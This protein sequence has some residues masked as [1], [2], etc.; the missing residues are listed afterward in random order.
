M[1]WEETIKYI[2]K[3]PEYKF[4]VETAYLEED[5]PLNIERFMKSEEFIQTLNL[6]KK[7]SSGG[8]TLLDI[9]SGN[10]ISAVAL[11]MNGY[12][13]TAVEPDPSE[14]IGAG[15]IRQLKIHYKLDNLEVREDFGEEIYSPSEFF[16]IVYARQCIHHAHN[17]KKFLAEAAR[18]LK[19][20]GILATIRDHV[21]F[22]KK[23]KNWFLESHPLHKFYGGENA[24]L[25]EEYTQAMQDAGLTILEELRYYDSVINYFPLNE[26]D[27]ME[28]P[29]TM[30]NNLKTSLKKRIG[31]LAELPFVFDLYKWKVGF[32][33]KDAFNEKRVPGRMY[34]YIAK[35]II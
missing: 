21:V 30:E 4:L 25:A 3:Q 17:L 14:T 35:K 6:L 15:A 5:L 32:S 24:F 16:D 31:S 33:K 27:K 23:D 7:Y 19:K 1:T 18:V 11:A 20:G 8:K 2:R 9:G 12:E 34:S 26:K 10:G 13:V 22:N 29:N 28:L